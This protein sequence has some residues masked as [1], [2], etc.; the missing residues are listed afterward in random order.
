M[1]EN[2]KFIS[3][4]EQDISLVDYSKLNIYIFAHFMSLIFSIYNYTNG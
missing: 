4:I 1:L 2:M 3:W